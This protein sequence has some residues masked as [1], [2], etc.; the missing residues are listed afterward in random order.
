M[1][2]W[3][4]NLRVRK[5]ILLI[6]SINVFL[7]ALMTLISHQSLNKVDE[8]KADIVQVGQA[9]S[10]QMTADMMHD[11][12]RADVYRAFLTEKTDGKGIE[13]VKKD[14]AEHV[15]IFKTS[16][17]ELKNLKVDRKIINQ[18]N[19]LRQP[20]N[21][22][23]N[24]SD[25]LINKGLYTRFELHSPYGNQA[26]NKYKTTFDKLAYR[27]EAMSSM[28]EKEYLKQQN[29]LT[30]YSHNV[31]LTL[32]L[33]GLIVAI[34]A[35]TLS[36]FVSKLIEKPILLTEEVL[37]QI[38]AGQITEPINVE[39]KDETANMLRS[40]NNVV[41]NLTNVKHYVT[42]VGKG[43]FETKVEIFQNN[44]EIYESLHSMTDAIKANVEE[45]KKRN[46]TSEGL[47]K[48]VDITRDIQDVDMFY[49]NI[50][51]SLIRYIN[52]N[53]G[54][55]YV[56]NNE[57]QDD[58]F[59]EIKAV[60]AYGKQRYLED[61]K[62]IRYKQG[63]VGQAW[64]D[65]EPLYFTEIPA[66]FVNITSGIGEATPRCVF[67]VPLMVNEKV[68]GVIEIASFEP[69]EIFKQE[70]V[71]KLSETIASTVDSAK[72]NE[73]TRILLELSQ[74]AEQA[75]KAQEEEIR[76]NME[77]MQA[78]QD[79]ME[80][81]QR[82]MAM[83]KQRIEDEFEAQLNII[84]NIA[85][86]S[87]TDIQGNIT[88]VN[89]NFLKWAKYTKEEV[90]GKNHRMLKSGDQDD[91]IFDE[92][93]KT[94][95]S[96]NVFRGE[97]K[98]KAKDG[99]FYWVDAI[100]APVLDK[101]GKPKEYIAQRFVIND[102]IAA[103]EKMQNIL[104]ETR[105]Q[106]EEIRQN[107]E[108]MSATQEHME[109]Q[110]L[111]MAQ[112]AIEQKGILD[113]INATMATIEFTPEGNVITANDNFL[114]T[115]KC[116]LKDIYGKHHKTFVPQEIQ[117]SE[118]YATFWTR[119]AAGID[120]KG[121]F[122]RIDFEGKTIWLEA[123][124]NPILDTEGNVTKVIKFATDITSR[125][126]LEAENKAQLDIINEIAIVS[127]TDL[128][129]N[130]TYVNDEFLKWAQYSIHEIIG[131]NHR[132]LKSGEQNDQI[133]VD[134]WK[135][136]SSGKI[137]RGE[138]KNKAKDGSFYWVDAIVA[139]IL[140]ENGKPKEYIAQR[141]VINDQKLKEQEMQEMLEETR[142]QEEEIRQNMEEV[143]AIQE[144]MERAQRE[145][146]A[147]TNIINSIAIVSKT[148]LQGNITYVNDEFLKW[149]KYSKEEVMGQNHRLLKSGDQDDQIFVDM[150]KTISSGKIFRGEI[151][152]KAKDGSIY[153]VDAIIAPILDNA[154]KPKEYIAQRFVINEQKEREAKL[155]ELLNKK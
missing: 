128:Q 37:G 47:A 93:W 53:Q 60:Y 76:Q 129:G 13:N 56:I 77:E 9:A 127:K 142:A 8:I 97:I 6:I 3:I 146:Q 71:K 79:E 115:M 42:E 61:K 57:N 14:F 152:N 31:Q 81:V 69:L 78:T 100:V 140:D 118:N 12:L 54:Y 116:T 131:K 48:F 108:E 45:D 138:I 84:N 106:E 132:I 110:N 24:T 153:W 35:I 86:V 99:S 68:L 155:N 40:L 49:N 148:D 85:I 5:K 66:D 112:N 139:P 113:G 135:T 137:F 80:R 136:I 72:T 114:A 18:V 133:F 95:S 16:L 82:S 105:A 151:K 117:Q 10:M 130:I 126:E 103:R 147:Q 34:I 119:L 67:I 91:A 63:L 88:Y 96:G 98:N 4:K 55:L 83:E 50:L 27:M 11:A 120:N 150:W 15:G 43:N 89:D 107:M 62:E 29:L 44:G 21:A 94:I 70:F 39:G 51:S 23:I 73:R 28:I 33:L 141:F 125:V 7:T 26:I 75:M 111:I 19:V 41:D 22:Y 124:Y 30:D 1:K 59:M 102:Q 38:S 122:K 154:G 123:I 90:M 143:T 145:I 144:Q 74:E 109:R 65:R 36:L 25:D 101:Q 92:M 20:L 46:W 104:E 121:I 64:F 2:T 134:M 87:K 58:I 17:K 149:A 32:F 52:A